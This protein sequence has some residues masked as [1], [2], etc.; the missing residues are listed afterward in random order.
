MSFG[1]S[2]IA[3]A[4]FLLKYKVTANGGTI[5]AIDQAYAGSA[6]N[7]LLAVDET[8]STALGGVPI[9]GSSHLTGLDISDPPAEG[10]DLLGIVPPHTVLY[11]TKDIRF[12]VTSSNGGSIG[13]SEVTQSFH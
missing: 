6:I 2:G 3:T 1:Y 4:D 9:V 5:D 8:V 13:I 11:V 10:N 7:G 12:A